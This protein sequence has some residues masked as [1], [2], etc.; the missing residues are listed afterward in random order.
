MKKNIL[1]LFLIL[2]VILIAGWFFFINKKGGSSWKE[3]TNNDYNFSLEYPEDILKRN[4]YD[5]KQF[6]TADLN[7]VE[8]KHSLSFSWTDDADNNY[9][10][11]DD[12]SLRVCVLN[13]NYITASEKFA[14]AKKIENKNNYNIFRVES[15]VEGSFANTYYI[16]LS[17]DKT[18]LLIHS[19]FTPFIDNKLAEEK[20]YIDLNKQKKM[21]QQILDSV[22]L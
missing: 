9:D 21:F 14:N 2:L 1:L 19:Y 7:G 5:C 12:M 4:N 22:K 3:Y 20:E 18:L 10:S 17:N 8:F 13:E 15:G 16:D 6:K 11:I